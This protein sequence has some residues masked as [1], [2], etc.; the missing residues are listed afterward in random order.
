MERRAEHPPIYTV[1]YGNRSIEE[2]I[3]L[4]QQYKIQYLVDIRS[5]PYSRFHPDF[6]KAALEEKLKQQG[7]RYIF[8][9][10]KLGGRPQDAECYVNN[11]VDYAIL[12]E[13]PFYQQGIQRLY[14]AR[15]KQACMALMCSEQKPQEC[16]RS[17]L[18]GNTLREKD[19]EVAHIDE[20]GRLK[21]QEE[22]DGI[23]SGGQLSL[24]DDP[25]LN[26]RTSLSRKKY[27]L[28]E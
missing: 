13:K 8:L 1:G 24:F 23:L 12:R 7:L 15:E 18:V 10:D 4:L 17:K 6:S 28:E 25:A 20:I 11:K 2:F 26:T 14:A 16:H 5:Q 27:I 21:S 19:I 9:G 3:A 22:V